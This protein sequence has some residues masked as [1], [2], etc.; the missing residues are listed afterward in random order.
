MCVCAS[1]SSGTEY[2]RNEASFT[3]F[4]FAIMKWMLNEVVVQSAERNSQCRV[5][6]EKSKEMESTSTLYIYRQLD[7]A[8]NR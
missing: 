2:A 1:A 7:Q 8:D 3:V 4:G 6:A 5:S